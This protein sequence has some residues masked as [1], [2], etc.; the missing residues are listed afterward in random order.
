VNR[1]ANGYWLALLLLAPASGWAETSWLD[2]EVRAQEARWAAQRGRT[3]PLQ[4]VGTPSAS[5]RKP[6]SVAH[7]ARPKEKTL[8]FPV[9][10]ARSDPVRPAAETAMHPPIPTRARPAAA[11]G[12]AGTLL[13]SAR[14]HGL[15][16]LLV[17]AVILAES[18]GRPRARSPKGA[19]GLMQLMPATA[20]RFGVADPD[21]PAQN[22]A[23]GTRYLRWLLDRF[24]GNVTLA[25]AGYNA[26]EG[27]VDR[28]GGIPPYRETQNYV[29]TVRSTHQWL[30]RRVA[31]KLARA[32]R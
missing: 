6:A 31:D 22:I 4:A 12:L 7:Q 9:V 25:L 30:R 3:A 24:G 11:P 23:G 8:A 5:L 17:K 21:D 29:R 16:P 10:A 2:A 18:A 19:M 15:D 13:A 26:G 32:A 1:P 14:Q 28:H 20:R 27:A